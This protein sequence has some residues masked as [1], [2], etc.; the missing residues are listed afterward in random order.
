MKLGAFTFVLHSHLPYCRQ[1]GRWPHGEEWIHEAATECY[2][3]LLRG[4][5]DLRDEGV[6]FKSTI[7]LTPILVEQLRDPLVNEHLEQYIRGLIDAAS[8]DVARH[9]RAGSER[10]AALAS[11]YRSLY[12]E[13]LQ[14]YLDRLGGDVVGAF[15]SLQDSG[16]IEI[17]TSAATH[18][19]LPLFE[20]ESSVAAQ[21]AVG[22]DAYR[23][24]FG[25]RPTAIWLPECAY[26]PARTVTIDG[27]PIRQ[28]GLE[29]VLADYDLQVFFSE[30]HTVEGGTPVGKAAGDTIGPYGDVPRRYSVPLSSPATPHHGTTFEP[31]YVGS[32]HVAVIARNNRTGMQVWSAEHGYPGDYAYREF[33][34]RDGVSGMRYWRITGRR[35]DLADK[36]EYDFDRA[37]DAMNS[38]ARHFA[39][40]VE[41]LVAGYHAQTGRY[42][43]VSCAYDTE[44][45]GHWWFEGTDWL[46]E[47]LRLLAASDVVDLTTASEF[48]QLHPPEHHITLP[49]SSWGQGG[50]DFTWKNVDTEWMWPVIHERERRI[51][52]IADRHT[53]ANDLEAAV[54]KQAARE[55]LLLQSSDW[56]FLV[57]T[58]QAREYAIERFEG[59]VER[60]D[61]LASALESGTV[62]AR[63]RALADELYDRDNPFADIDW[64]TF[65]SSTSAQPRRRSAAS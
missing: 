7:G 22:L 40:L 21:V 24:I 53:H 17:A 48:V 26:R 4:L 34:K 10:L 2:V 16:H 5:W 27:V 57:T 36:A 47:V 13:T 50:G 49:E 62:D 15:K 46:R 19:Y 56:P 60:F 44:L 55:A 14:T 29:E 32:T 39:Q 9:Q 11:R 28:A 64:R 25:R 20:R 41:D 45:F 37:R 6:A 12:A 33:H 51:E 59:H 58:G 18:G 3:P 38:H 31:Y 54:L 23:R 63:A 61:R 42:G 43:I 52:C 30:T 65:Q 8:S 35:V 1:A